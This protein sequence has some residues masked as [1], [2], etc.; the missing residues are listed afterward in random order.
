[1]FMETGRLQPPESAGIIPREVPR[2]FIWLNMVAVIIPAYNE[3]A[4]IRR[5]L[6]SLLEGASTTDF[7]I[8]VCCNGCKDSTAR[9]A[10][11]FGPPVTVLET[12]KGSKTLALNMG[13]AAAKTFPRIYL[14]AD[15]CLSFDAVQKIAEALKDEHVLAVAPRMRVDLTGSPWLIRAFH[16]V[17]LSTPYHS[18]GMIGSGVYAMSEAGRKRFVEFPPIIADDAFARA[19]FAPDER[20]I[21]DNCEFRMVPP[22]RLVDLIKIKTRAIVGDMELAQKHPTLIKTLNQR[23]GRRDKIIWLMGYLARPWLWPKF[24]VYTAVK[25]I[26][27]FRARKQIKELASYVWERDLSSRKP[28]DASTPS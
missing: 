4:V 12:P 21:L 7:E 15:I 28:S 6:E 19:Q 22:S 9:I 18:K 2:Y 10:R 13:D 8:I 16:D 25:S 11:E 23:E 17:W 1:M 20:K 27:G 3:E 26:A 24:A 5:S 14:D